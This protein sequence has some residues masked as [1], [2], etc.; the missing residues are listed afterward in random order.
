MSAIWGIVALS[1]DCSIPEHCAQLFESTY[2]KSCKIDRYESVFGT[3]AFFGCGIQ[4]ITTE[5]EQEQLPIRH[6]EQ[7]L[8]FTADCLLDN[9]EELIDLLSVHGYNKHVL[10]DAPD[11][12]LMYYSYL[13]FGNDCVTHFRGLFSFAV[14]EENTRTMTLFSDHTSSRSLYYILQNGLLAFSTRMEPLLKLFPEVT[15]N[16]NYHKDFLLA[17]ASVVY[18][19]PGETPYREISL[20]LPATRLTLTKAGASPVTYW[21][22]GSAPQN[23]CRSAKEYSKYFLALYENCVRDA[24]RTSGET[25]ISMSSGLDSTS[26]G[27]LAAKELA[28]KDKTLHSYTFV[29]YYPR[30]RREGNKAVY[31]ESVFVTDLAKQ[32]PNIRTIVLNN[33]G[34]NLFTDM[35]L[36]SNI[37]E[38]PYKTAPFPNHH[39]ICCDS[40]SHG[41]KLLLSGTFGNHTVSFGY[42]ENILYDLYCKKKLVS[43][44]RLI[45]LYAKHEHISRKKMLC[46]SLQSF[47]RFRKHMRDPF[48][49]YVPENIFL[50]I[51]LK[52]NYSL[53][54]RFS[55]DAYALF[56]NGFVDRKTFQRQLSPANY[57]VYA[58]VFETQF[59][60]HTGMLLRDPTKDIRL[61][62]FCYRLPFRMFAHRGIP[63]W[64]IRSSFSSLLPSS[65][66]DS[67]GQHG[68]INTDWLQ[69]V[70]RD[71][72]SLKPEILQHLNTGLL[73]NY[74][75]KEH[76]L[77]FI[78]AFE[79]PQKGDADRMTHLCALE[80]LLRFLLPESDSDT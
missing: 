31:D 28:K 73:D 38:M 66:L 69:R 75:D 30:E 80:G 21:T 59:G 36:C 51:T 9:R 24:L 67:W 13:T 45:N 27:V 23:R 62:D 64:L 70:R 32:Y 33:Q 11:G 49:R 60:L 3:D 79:H 7:G 63:R 15:P 71:W 68:L 78:E 37:L 39:E 22:P 41:C 14:W 12:T 54:T 58:G 53:R 1:P 47:H 34:K 46:S 42:I 56:S 26:I 2:K 20:M 18:V 57:F 17:N 77:S 50:S 35:K 44:L 43:F 65:I 10:A 48:A 40:A 72:D 29:P 55:G 52:Q 5:A 76:V 19:V 74:I 61:I 4:Y 8:L 25:G 6:P 16:I